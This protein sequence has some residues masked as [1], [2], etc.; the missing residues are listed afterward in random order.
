MTWSPPPG[1]ERAVLEARARHLARSRSGETSEDRIS[2]LTFTLG[3]ERYALDA[4]SVRGVFRLRHLVPLPGA[5][6]RV[7]GLT[8]WRGHILTVLDLERVLGIERTG[9]DDRAWVVV[10]ESGALP[11]GLLSGE[12]GRLR[13]VPESSIRNLEDSAA[14]AALGVTPDAVLVL[15]TDRLGT[16]LSGDHE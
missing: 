12:M 14:A 8:T 13:E 5:T 1:D 9:L 11:F 7:A 3:S 16:T 15:D 2:L 6:P 10:A 4:R